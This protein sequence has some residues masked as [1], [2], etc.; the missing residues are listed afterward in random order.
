LIFEDVH[1]HPEEHRVG[2][3][4]AFGHSEITVCAEWCNKACF[5]LSSMRSQI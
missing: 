4:E 2:I 3:H 5:S 1:H